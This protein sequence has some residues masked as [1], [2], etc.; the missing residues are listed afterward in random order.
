MWY[1]PLSFKVQASFKVVKNPEEAGLE[2]GLETELEAGMKRA[3]YKTRKYMRVG[4][5]Q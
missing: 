1:W 4:K 3:G 5:T 2:A